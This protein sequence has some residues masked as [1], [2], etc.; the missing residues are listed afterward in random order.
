MLGENMARVSPV[1]LEEAPPAARA[2]WERQVKNHGRMTNMKRTLARSPEALEAYM[3][4]YGLRDEVEKFLGPRLTVL[5]AH[6]ISSESDCLICSTYFRKSM[7]DTGMN[8][9]SLVLDDKERTLTDFGRQIA[10]DPR[11]VGDELFERVQAY[12]EPD[13]ILTVT[14]FAGL[15]VATN[16]VNNVLEVDLDDYLESYRPGGA[17]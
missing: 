6:A 15:M 8:P 4:W 13:E 9:D 10:R 11:A 14:A 5:L 2:E 1:S 16:I 7:R 3:K 12:L 17:S